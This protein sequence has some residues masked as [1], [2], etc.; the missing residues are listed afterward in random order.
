METIITMT[1]S[2]MITSVLVMNAPITK[3]IGKMDGEE[4]IYK[5]DVQNE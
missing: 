1:K 5:K 3:I 2:W 4:M